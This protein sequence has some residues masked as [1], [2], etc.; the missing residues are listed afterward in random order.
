MNGV[1]II[2]TKYGN[3]HTGEINTLNALQNITEA[4][5][6]KKEIHLR[7]LKGLVEDI[8]NKDIEHVFVAYENDIN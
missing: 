4:I 1:V 7:N 6:N 8:P 3:E 5:K 2:R